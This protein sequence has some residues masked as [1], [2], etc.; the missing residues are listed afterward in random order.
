MLDLSLFDHPDYDGHERVLH[1]YDE[2]S[3]AKGVIAIH[4][5]ARGPSLGGCRI[6]PYA[7]A[8]EAVTDALRL[9]RGMTYKAALANLD[10]GGGKAVVMADPKTDKS[11][12]FFKGLAQAVNDLNGRYITAE[13]V[14]T[15]VKDMVVI[16]KYTS[17]VVGLPENLDQDNGDPSP[18]TSY[19]IY[20]GI[21]ASAMHRFHADTLSGLTVAV[22]GVGKVGYHL[23]HL[24]H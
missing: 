17:H 22:Q 3:G 15:T 21:R 6:W 11:E 23:C 10:L 12:A 19:G 1:F 8:V 24:L 14:G 5:T 18:Y 16:K 7:T 9:S 4:N 20:Q 2:K 13:D